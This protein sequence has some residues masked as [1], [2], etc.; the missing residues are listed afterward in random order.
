MFSFHVNYEEVKTRDAFIAA[1][2]NQKKMHSSR[3]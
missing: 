1:V 3:V 2:I